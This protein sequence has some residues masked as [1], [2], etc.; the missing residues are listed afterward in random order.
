MKGLGS[1]LKYLARRSRGRQGG[2]EIAECFLLSVFHKSSK[3]SC[4][5]RL[6]STIHLSLDKSIVRLRR[7]KTVT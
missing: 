5:K 1:A 2:A 6:P 4:M 7:C 3:F